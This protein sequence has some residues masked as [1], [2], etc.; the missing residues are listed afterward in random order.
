MEWLD[1]VPELAGRLDRGC[2]VVIRSA[3]GEEL[4]EVL[5]VAETSPRAVRAVSE[6]DGFRSKLV[7][8]A[9]EDDQDRARLAD[10]ARPTRF[11]ECRHLVEDGRW[12]V[13]LL[14]VELL[15][16]GGT[17]VVNLI[18]SDDFDLTALRSQFR[19]WF[20]FEVI[21]EPVGREN[22]AV[23]FISADPALMRAATAG[24]C[25]SGGCGSGGCGCRPS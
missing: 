20:D 2:A 15:L 22:E 21:L 6:A 9:D 3:R 23:L 10:A 5:M 16:D 24:G 18:K 14:D 25:G 11:D 1:V 17:T 19:D 13:E 8:I 4:A 7:R 12:P